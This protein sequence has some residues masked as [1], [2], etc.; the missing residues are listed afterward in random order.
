[1]PAKGV[2]SGL[3]GNLRTLVEGGRTLV[4]YT[5]NDSLMNNFVNHGCNLKKFKSLARNMQ[6][7]LSAPRTCKSLFNEC[8]FIESAFKE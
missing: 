4:L 5:K 6:C 1:M 2:W 8:L 7:V 3:K